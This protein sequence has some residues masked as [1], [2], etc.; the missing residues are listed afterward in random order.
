MLSSEQATAWLKGLDLRGVTVPYP[1]G[2]IVLLEDE[3]R[4][5]LGR[6]KALRDRVRNL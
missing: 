5:Y 4:R 6:G 3:K 1:R 2:S